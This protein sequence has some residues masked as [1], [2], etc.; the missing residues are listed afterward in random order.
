MEKINTSSQSQNTGKTLLKKE[1]TVMNDPI[2]GHIEISPLCMAIVDTPQFQRL[3]FIKMT[4][5]GSLVYPGAVHTRFEHSIGVCH[6]AETLCRTLQ[7]KQPE[8]NITESDVSCV[9]VAGLCHDLGHGPFSHLYDQL[10]VPSFRR[11]AK[12]PDWKHEK[13]SVDMLDYIIKVNNLMHLF[14]DE[15]LIFIKEQIM[16]PT[17]KD[18]QGRGQ[19]KLFLYEI[20]AN[21]RTG[22]DVDR[23][24]YFL[25]D[26]YYL[27]LKV[28]F[29]PGR[30]LKFVRVINVD[31]EKQICARN[32]EADNL[33]EMFHCRSTLFK[34]AYLH[35]TTI[36]H[37]YMICEALRLADD[38]L[39]FPGTNGKLYKM[40]EGM[41]D[42]EAFWKMTDDIILQILHSSRPELSRSRE[43][44][45]RVFSRD[46]PKIV[47]VIKESDNPKLKWSADW[48]H[49]Q[50]VIES[51][52][53]K[54]DLVADDFIVV[55]RSF[56]YG[57]KEKNP[58][59]NCMFYGK[60]DPD[61]AYKITKEQV[62]PFL[63]EKFHEVQYLVYCNEEEKQSLANDVYGAFCH[64][65]NILIRKGAEQ[66]GLKMT[67]V[68]SNNVL[69]I[70]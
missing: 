47:G 40:S 22:I 21:N 10:F 30:L 4:G 1:G 53:L 15:D 39:S 51:A 2:H 66:I 48:I 60:R 13:A 11:S 7:Q 5:T 46:L 64:K 41:N 28:S 44:I 54:K 19:D 58:L 23:W 32:K 42:M 37:N 45:K 38:H 57:M 63:P 33:Y 67:P 55:K 70:S 56:N 59:E 34:Q 16:S 8:L 62:S 3:R 65:H 17:N 20:V 35:K 18:Y 12:L 50:L 26:S 68:I 27:G 9:A 25:R 52:L 49:E 24:D 61:V 14:S 36:I 31:G 43:W 69:Q 6:L 29:D